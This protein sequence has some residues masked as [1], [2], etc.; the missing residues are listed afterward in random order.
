MGHKESNQAENILKLKKTLS[1]SKLSGFASAKRDRER[2]KAYGAR[3]T[4]LPIIF[5][6][7]YAVQAAEC[8]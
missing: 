3:K 5:T 1:D 4:T 2:E 6:F 7:L 8:V